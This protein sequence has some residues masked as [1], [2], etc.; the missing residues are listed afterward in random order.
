MLEPSLVAARDTEG[1]TCLHYAALNGH[2]ALA[3]FLVEQGADVNSRDERFGATPAGWAIEY[4]REMGGL[5]GIEINDM[6]FAIQQGDVRWVRRLLARLP[7][8]AK[9]TD[10]HGKP[11]REYA[12]DSKHPE[13]AR[14]FDEADK[15]WR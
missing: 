2:Q 8:F 4:L 14:L 7:A 12:E 6:I 1:A 13:I 10:A 11:L 15:R 9:G 3:R 5:L